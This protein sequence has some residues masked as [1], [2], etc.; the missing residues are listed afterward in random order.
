MHAQARPRTLAGASQAVATPE[1]AGD[2][3]EGLPPDYAHL[4]RSYKLIL[5]HHKHGHTCLYLPSP[6]HQRQGM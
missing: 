2:E 3:C 5:T 4:I 1:R 6:S